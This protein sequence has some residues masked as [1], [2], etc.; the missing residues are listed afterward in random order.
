MK[1]ISMLPILAFGD[2]VGND[3][4]AVHKSLKKAGYD[5]MI[6]ASVIDGRLGDGI[7]QSADDLSFIQPEDIVIYH[8]STGHELNQRF[9]RLDCRKII[10]YHNITPPE[11]FFGYNTSALVNCMEGYRALHMLSKQAEFCFADSDYNKKEMEKAGYKCPIEV[12]PIL[13]PFDDYQKT[14]DAAVVSQ[15]TADGYTNILFT[16]RI[17]PN[18]RQEDVI[19]AFYHYHKYY[20]PK[21]R[22]ILI[23]NY[24]GM[25][26]Y[27]ESLQ[28]YIRELGAEDILFPGH[29]SFAQI[30]AYYAT[31]DLFLCMSDHEGFCVPLIE[32]MNFKVPILAK[33]TSAIPYTLGGSGMMLE[34]Q[35]PLTAAAAMNRI[36]TDEALK[37]TIISNQNERLKDFEHDKIEKQLLQAI[38]KIINKQ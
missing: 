8:L 17:V 13:I 7:A 15:M 2:A 28:R 11:F 16:G 31:A 4:V 38:E 9:A 18:K 19:A 24:T 21:S 30:L 1:I 23:G 27:Y 3:T 12:L 22:L 5:S 14:P 33:K 35:E 10:K 6:V 32:A 20:N 34:D 36:L 25:E 26:S 29:I 37:K